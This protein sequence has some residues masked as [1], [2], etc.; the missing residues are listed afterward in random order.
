MRMQELNYL[1]SLLSR[2][3]VPSRLEHIQ[4]PALR[5]DCKPCQGSFWVATKAIS[6]KHWCTIVQRQHFLFAVQT[7]SDQSHPSSSLHAQYHLLLNLG[8]TSLPPR[9]Q[10]TGWWS[11]GHRVLWCKTNDRRWKEGH[12]V[13][14]TASEQESL[15]QRLEEEVGRHPCALSRDLSRKEWRFLSKGHGVAPVYS[16]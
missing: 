1:W 9:A 3:Y 16:L 10:Q 5:W 14:Y 8:R 7:H 12:P 11:T 6:C 15:T 2:E 4:S 13:Q